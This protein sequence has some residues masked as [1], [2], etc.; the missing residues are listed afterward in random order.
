MY[1][2]RNLRDQN[3]IRCYGNTSVTTICKPMKEPC[4]FDIDADPCELNNLARAHPDILNNILNEIN[5]LRK[6]AVPPNNT[7][8]DPRGDPK[9]FNYVWTNFG[10]QV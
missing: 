5:N 8:L 6:T 3:N 2:S 4:L 1:S 9:N 7:P 10:D